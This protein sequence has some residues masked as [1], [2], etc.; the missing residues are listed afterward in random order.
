LIR[1]LNRTD[2]HVWQ[3]FSLIVAVILLIGVL[4]WGMIIYWLFW[5]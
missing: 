4:F 5:T 2:G 1:D 3:T